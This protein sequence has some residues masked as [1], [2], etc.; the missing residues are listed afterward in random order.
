M[1]LEVVQQLEQV[2][3]HDV[4]QLQEVGGDDVELVQEKDDHQL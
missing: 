3:Q 1:G 4:H 2:Q